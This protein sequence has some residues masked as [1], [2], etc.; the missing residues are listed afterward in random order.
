MV[1]RG[2]DLL[3]GGD[4]TGKAGRLCPLPGRWLDSPRHPRRFGR[5]SRSSHHLA[6][7]SNVG[8]WRHAHGFGLGCCIT[9]CRQVRPST[10]ARRARPRPVRRSAFIASCGLPMASPLTWHTSA[11][12]WPSR[13]QFSPGGVTVPVDGQVDG[14]QADELPSIFHVTSTQPSEAAYLK[15][16]QDSLCLVVTVGR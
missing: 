6:T 8:Q 13:M 4:G 16:N 14:A 15:T 12:R 5:R 3:R 11:V 10:C 1:A 9:E 7:S 2:S